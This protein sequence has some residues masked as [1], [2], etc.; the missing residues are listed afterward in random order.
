MKK[1]VGAGTVSCYPSRQDICWQE[2]EENGRRTT[3]GFLMDAN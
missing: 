3:G 1:A 2:E